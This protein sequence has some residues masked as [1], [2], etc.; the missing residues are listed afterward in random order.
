MIKVVFTKK[1]NVMF[2]KD[3]NNLGLKKKREIMK[4][5]SRLVDSG[6]TLHIN[7][8]FTKKDK[9]E[10]LWRLYGFDK[11]TIPWGIIISDSSSDRFTYEE[12]VKRLSQLDKDFN[13]I[14]YVITRA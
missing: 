3:G 11:N 8:K 9:D 7:P 12:V 10:P 1:I 2:N 4:E 5:L 13:I 6:I 14:S